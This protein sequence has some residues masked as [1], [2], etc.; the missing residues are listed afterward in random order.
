MIL[1]HQ[2]SNLDLEYINDIKEYLKYNVL[3]PIIEK[4]VVFSNCKGFEDKIKIESKKIKYFEVEINIF[5]M[6]KYGKNNTRNFVIYSTPFI[7]FDVDLKKILT[8]DKAN[9]FKE[10]NCY[11]IFDRKMDI[12]NDRNIEDVLSGKKVD[13]K[14]NIQKNGYY[15]NGFQ[16]K[17]Y[18]W[19]VSKTF[20]ILDKKTI[21]T[22]KKKS[23]DIKEK[24]ILTETQILSFLKTDKMRKLENS[25][26]EKNINENLVVKRVG[27]KKLDV[28]I[29]SVNYN[30]F[31]L[32]SLGHNEKIFENITVVTSSSD[33]LCQKICKKF[34][35]N[36]VVTDI[37]YEND[38]VFNKGKAINEGI[39]SISNPDYILLLDADI[40]VMENIDIDALDEKTL[41]TSD[42]YFIKD[43]A[44]Y[45]AYISGK[46]GKD[47]F[48]LENDKGFGFFQLF[49]YSKWKTFPES[50]EDASTSD[51][52]FRDKF[53]LKKGID[54][55]VFHIGDD[56]NWK[57]RKSK[58][59]LEYEQFNVLLEKSHNLPVK[60]FKICTFY[61]NPTK[62]VRREKNLLRFLSQFEEHQDK[63][64]IGM[65]DY[66]VDILPEHL[67]ENVFLLK[68]EH[69]TPIWYKE[70]LLNKMIDT[71]EEE[72]VIWI[73]CD[74]I[75]EN[76]DWLKNINSVVRG[77]DFVQLFETINYLDE[78]GSVLESHKSIIS[79]GSNDIDR[80]L[81]EGYKPGGSWIGKT[82]ILKDKK[83]FEKMYVGGGDTIF[84]Y[85]LFGIEDGF[86]LRQVK[87][88]S[89]YIWHGAVEWIKS[90]KKY[91]LGYLDVSINHLYH[92][93]LKDR[94][95]NERYSKLRGIKAKSIV[96]FTENIGGYDNLLPIL[97]YENT[98][99]VAFLDKDV[100]I[101]G[102]N[103]ININDYPHISG[104]KDVKL[105]CKYVRTHP[106]ELL[107]E[108]DYSLH[109][110]ANMVLTEDPNKIVDEII[111]TEKEIMVFRHHK[112]N[113]IYEE[114]KQCIDWKL[115][116]ESRISDQMD[117]YRN[118][119]IGIGLYE[120]GLM[121]R[122]NTKSVKKFDDIW[123]KEI[124]R[125]SKRDQLAFPYA[126]GLAGVSVG[127]FSIEDRRK[128]N[129]INIDVDKKGNSHKKSRIFNNNLCFIYDDGRKNWGST[130]MR[131][132]DI[133]EKI[134]CDIISFNE[135]K[136][137]RYK[138]IVL[139]KMSNYEK[140]LFLTEFNEVVCDMVDFNRLQHNLDTF[141]RFDYGIFTS[142]KQMEELMYIFKSPEKCRVIYHHWD[143]RFNDVRVRNE[144]S[145]PKICYIG[146]PEKCY[147]QNTNIER[148]SI[149]WYDFDEK[150]SLY[151]QYNVHYV[152]KPKV[153]DDKIQPL[154]KISTA[155]SLGCPVIANRSNHNIELLGSD[156]PYY[157]DPDDSSVD[158]VIEKVYNTFGGDE[159][160]LALEKMKEIKEMT[161][162]KRII[163]NYLDLGYISHEEELSIK[164]DKNKRRMKIYGFY[165]AALINDWKSI[166]I[167]QLER[168]FHSNLL[169][170]T[171]LLFIRVYY[172]TESD[173]DDFNKIVDSYRNNFQIDI[174]IHSTNENEY[175]FGILN[176]I[177]ELATEDE[178]YCYY[179]HSKGVSKMFD[180]WEV[181]IENISAW[182]RY[183]EY[184]LIDK[185][186]YCIESLENGS[187]AVGVKMRE[188]PACMEKVSGLSGEF[189]WASSGY[190]SQNPK[191]FSGNFWW[192]KSS[193]IMSLPDIDSIRFG[194]RHEA[195]FWIGYGNGEMKCLHSGESARY[196]KMIKEEEYMDK[197]DITLHKK[198]SF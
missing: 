44:T 98:T 76:L 96:V 103:V 174:N 136:E 24:K 84:V 51:I 168:L 26:S 146:Q 138:K 43:Y 155:A 108:H 89:E 58:S 47:D 86:T 53:Y 126:T 33:F 153:E 31:L 133:S 197:K 145:S 191:H 29:V 102:W 194:D 196:K 63:I 131:G 64:L 195:E 62:D 38:A 69:K 120:C 32:V 152:V 45:E 113:S 106:N 104:L 99:C 124:R 3:N 77:K 36:C 25:V 70:I 95:Y 121:L 151:E 27:P 37:M 88:N 112:R 75:Y 166:V 172:T 169:D 55:K 165:F 147:G 161:S 183:M 141:K 184:F 60:T 66:D 30:D 171:N 173:M 41:Y 57:G 149:D 140:A 158:E 101:E 132:K 1:I 68:N 85:G 170:D 159:W 177:K 15:I 139:L 17:S 110:D 142:V 163:K 154:T 117:K 8:F 16:Y 130:K 82:S 167:N 143:E 119:G 56:S 115:D 123:W 21:K 185:Y 188:T 87:K 105:I 9:V 94:N 148:H 135:S 160:Y 72:Y 186:S 67:K 111:G 14:L 71:I 59:F 61:Y 10:E 176:M 157:C 52:Q 18:D 109:I 49:N 127:T 181:N 128:S 164:E 150:I 92:G 129:L 90:C 22:V 125:Y 97:K 189:W 187:D 192:S 54:N 2:I 12:K 118:L 122:K 83:F 35:V 39:K 144:I 134:G 4:I 91:R 78:N 198:N 100:E 20:E 19:R 182:R 74:L 65:V 23:E 178:F 73:D 48:I 180:G 190:M 11:Y 80:L 156:Y 28:I 175:E 13:L 193:Y 93:E 114:G 34:G 5:D 107:P 179:L 137:I 162:L 116:S 79:S 6:M 81:G 46:I 42:R 7:R 40:L 50:S